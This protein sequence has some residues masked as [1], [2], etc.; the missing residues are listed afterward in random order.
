M[1]SITKVI[2]MVIGCAAFA[3]GAVGT[4]LPILPTVPFFL[5]AAVCFAKSSEKLNN[6]FKNTKLYKD[7]LE[8]YVAGKGMTMKTKIRIMVMV[9]I[10]MAVGF[11][12]MNE[13]LIGRIVLGAV[14]IFHIIYFLAGVK[15]I[16]VKNTPEEVTE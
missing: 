11:V 14:W 10:L 12:M 16:T 15:T 1:K 4:V 2:L 3:L 8:S 9:T 6:W 7:N 5:L 13:V